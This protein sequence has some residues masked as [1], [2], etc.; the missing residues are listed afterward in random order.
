MIL[1]GAGP[2]NALAASMM[3][4]VER[5]PGVQFRI[6]DLSADE[7][8]VLIVLDQAMIGIGRK[9][10]RAEAQGVQHRQAQQPQLGSRDPEMGN[11]ERDQVV[12]D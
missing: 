2:M 1:R 3:W 11:V 5:E 10:Q 7:A 8:A 12:A 6:V 9:G 4:V